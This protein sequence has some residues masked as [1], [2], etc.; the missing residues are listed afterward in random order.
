M[1]AIPAWHSRIPAIRATLG[2]LEEPLLDRAAIETLFGLGRRQAI[3][4]LTALGGHQAGKTFLVTR[5]ALLERLD[6]LAAQRPIASEIARRTRVRDAL[7]AL[8]DEVRSSAPSIRRE[9]ALATPVAAPPPA[10]RDK[11]PEGVSLDRPGELLIRF[12]TAEELLGRIFALTEDAAA[13]FEGFL[14]KIAP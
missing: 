6:A 8:E 2:R 5:D 7:L 9:K 3:R 1:P 11:W 14:K 13:D 10:S 4:L 12:E